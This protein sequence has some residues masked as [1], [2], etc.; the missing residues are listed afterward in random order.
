MR[1]MTSTEKV[2]H[3]YLIWETTDVIRGAGKA[4]TSAAPPVFSEIHVARSVV[5]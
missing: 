2:S 4:Y 5:F 3:K 1:H